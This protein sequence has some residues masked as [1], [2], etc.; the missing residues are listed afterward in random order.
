MISARKITLVLADN[1]TANKNTASFFGNSRIITLGK[2][3]NKSAIKTFETFL[4][5]NAT[6]AAEITV[7]H[8]TNPN[9]SLGKI[10]KHG[11]L[12]VPPSV[13]RVSEFL[14]AIPECYRFTTTEEE[15]ASVELVGFGEVISAYKKLMTGDDFIYK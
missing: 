4:K 5:R 8:D 2:G 3:L 10:I 12:F 9:E 11:N 13:C 7:F 15:L 14:P 1:K 6:C